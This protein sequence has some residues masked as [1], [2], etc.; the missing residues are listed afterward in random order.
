MD[1]IINT[2]DVD[3]NSDEEVEVIKVLTKSPEE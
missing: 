3:M 2:N 1:D